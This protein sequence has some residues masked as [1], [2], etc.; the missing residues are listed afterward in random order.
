MPES[1]KISVPGLSQ[2]IQPVDPGMYDVEV[3]SLTQ[4]TTKAGDP[5]L[6]MAMTIMDD[7]P[8]QGRSVF[9]NFQP[10]NAVS[11]QILARVCQILNIHVKEDGFDVREFEGKQLRVSVKHRLDEKNN[12][13]RADVDR[14]YSLA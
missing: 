12:M 8:F 1:T 13:I 6:R 4:T 3:N 7:G 5:M 9:A 14:F 10:R 2:E 11:R